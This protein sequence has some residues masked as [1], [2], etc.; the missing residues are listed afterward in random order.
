MTMGESR[1][2]GDYPEMTKLYEKVLE[3]DQKVHS[4]SFKLN[5]YLNKD[6]VLPSDSIEIKTHNALLDW[7]SEGKAFFKKLKLRYYDANYRGVHA[8]QKIHVDN[9]TPSI[10]A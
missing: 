9:K 5:N 2:Y 10:S 7:L 4:S 8:A 1:K 6:K 3:E